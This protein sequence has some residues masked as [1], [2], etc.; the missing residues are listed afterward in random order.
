MVAFMS[1]EAADEHGDSKPTSFDLRRALRSGIH[2]R[3][4]FIGSYESI[5]KSMIAGDESDLMI[6]RGKKYFQGP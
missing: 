6:L 1:S 4:S 5:T 3:N 2:H